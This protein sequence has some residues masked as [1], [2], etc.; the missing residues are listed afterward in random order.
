MTKKLRVHLDSQLWK[1]PHMRIGSDAWR[2]A[3]ARHSERA[4]GLD[5]SFGED[6]GGLE[7][8]LAEADVLICQSKPPAAAIANA[9]RLKWIMVTM[10]G[11]ESLAPLD[12]L[13]QGV[14]LSNNSGTHYPKT[15]EF[16]QMALGML[17]F[18]MPHL[19]TAQRAHAW[20]PRF[21]G[22]IAGR[23]V[24]VVGFGTLGQATADAAKGMGLKVHAV[25]RNPAPHALADAVFAPEDLAAACRSADFLV[26]TLPL[27]PA[28]RNMV[29]AAAFDALRPGAG[30]VNIGRGPVMDYAALA[31]RLEDG[32][33][34]GAILD[35]FE[36]EPL[37]ADD[38]LWD[39]KNLIVMP[40]MSSDD[41]TAYIQRSFDVFFQNLDAFVAGAGELP[42]EISRATGY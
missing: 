12:W 36:P 14:R 30:V 10:A 33:L 28:T 25:R 35:V 4:T 17:H 11:V 31:A 34:S 23:T 20:A 1:E 27:T 15:R 26:C 7:A 9:A 29:G 41:P 16:A 13:P 38:P 2:T 8:A 42:T 6:W 3:A 22:L 21:H 18:E 32:R 19:A 37:P 24:V 5:L 39:V 40:H